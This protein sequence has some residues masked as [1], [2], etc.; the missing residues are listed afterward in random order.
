RRRCK[1]VFADFGLAFA[2]ASARGAL[3]SALPV[4][5]PNVRGLVGQ[6]R[7]R[8]KVSPVWTQLC[9][10]LMRRKQIEQDRP[11]ARRSRLEVEWLEL[12][13]APAAYAATDVLVQYEAG[14]DPRPALPAGARVLAHLPLAS[15]L[16][17]VSLPAG[18]SVSQMLGAVR[19]N[20]H[21][22]FAQPDY[23]L[24]AAQVPND[25]KFPTQWGLNNTGQTSG[26]IGADIHAE[27]A[28]DVTT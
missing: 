5:C 21:V 7:R 27:K 24:Q 14:F 15:N 28:W 9:G 4:A 16:D 20:P 26:T 25:A 13:L 2:A 22:L 18:W 8:G 10:G 11:G 19:N 17:V 6:R 23:V 1:D 12:R 3:P